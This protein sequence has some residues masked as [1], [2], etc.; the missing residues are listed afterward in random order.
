MTLGRSK[1]NKDWRVLTILMSLVLKSVI[2][3]PVSYEI[4]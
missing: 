3:K 4:Q 2:K 1:E